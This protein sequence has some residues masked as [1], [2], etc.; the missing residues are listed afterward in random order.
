M[1]Y[2]PLILTLGRLK[3]GDCM[4]SVNPGYKFETILNKRVTEGDKRREMEGER[5]GGGE[6]SRYI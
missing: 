3:Q 4:F 2:T 6:R 5:K 1:V